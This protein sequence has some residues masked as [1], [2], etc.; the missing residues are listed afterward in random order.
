MLV[1]SLKT[2]ISQK[3]LIIPIYFY[4]NGYHFSQKLFAIPAPMSR[5]FLQFCGL[6]CV[7]GAGASMLKCHKTGTSG[8]HIKNK[9][10]LMEVMD[11]LTIIKNTCS[12][13]SSKQVLKLYWVRKTK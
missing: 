9:P 7:L 13:P 8:R 4:Y 6:Q 11:L 2:E 5:S 1:L 12:A 3:L 10:Y